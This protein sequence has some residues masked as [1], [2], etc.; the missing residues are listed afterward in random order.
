MYTSLLS[1]AQTLVEKERKATSS[2]WK[3][4]EDRDDSHAGGYGFYSSSKHRAILRTRTHGTATETRAVEI[5]TELIESLIENTGGMSSVSR[6]GRSLR[7]QSRLG[8]DSES[9]LL[10]KAFL[11]FQEMKRA[12][13]QIDLPC[14]NTLLRVCAQASDFGRAKDVLRRIRSDDLEPND[15]SWRLVMRSA[16]NANESIDV[17]ESIWREGMA[18]AEWIP[19]IESFGTLLSA[20][21]KAASLSADQ[22][23]CLGYYRN[24]VKL[25]DDVVLGGNDELGIDRIDRDRLFDSPKAMLVILQAI[26]AL[27]SLLR[28]D[29]HERERQGLRSMAGYITRLES[30]QPFQDPASSRGRIGP[31]ASDALAL[32]L[33]WTK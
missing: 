16:S 14:Y 12:G 29:D 8:Q 24:V 33:S 26:V 9:L 17:I 7:Q 28:G 6:Y 22:D 25:Y 30:L 20:Y 10:L 23:V 18:A 3:V 19:S 11:L 13:V 1:R 21:M 15:T 2:S 4:E 31:M 32:A 27:V 5:Y